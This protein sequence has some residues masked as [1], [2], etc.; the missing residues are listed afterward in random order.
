MLMLDVD[1]R[2]LYYNPGC[3]CGLLVVQVLES[4]LVTKGDF[5]HKEKV[6]IK[7]KVTFIQER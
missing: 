6:K 7:V 4:K 1:V 3:S 5:Q 2:T